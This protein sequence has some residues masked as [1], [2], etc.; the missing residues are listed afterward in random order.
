MPEPAF[1]KRNVV[2]RIVK[3]YPQARNHVYTGQIVGY[4][5]NFVTIDG[6]VLHF[7]KATVDDPTGGLTTSGRAMRWVA[8]DR[9]E[10]IR[11]LPD[12]M[13]P[14]SPENLRVTGDGSLDYNVLERPDLL[15]E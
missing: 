8:V 10:Y 13:D 7:G 11:E 1:A 9:V 5:G 6:C 2:I 14:F 4:D 12:G 3:L 15:P